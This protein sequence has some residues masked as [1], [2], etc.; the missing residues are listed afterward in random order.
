MKFDTMEEFSNSIKQCIADDEDGEY[1]AY[2]DILDNLDLLFANFDRLNEYLTPSDLKIFLNAV[3][4][5]GMVY[6]SEVKKFITK[7]KEEIKAELQK[8][9]LSHYS[10]FDPIVRNQK[11]QLPSFPVDML[12]VIIKTYIKEVSESI[13]VPDDMVASMVLIVMS[14]CMQG[15]FYIN[16]K[17]DW[18]ESL[19]LYVVVVGRPS[20]RKS[21]T[22]KEVTR[23]IF[24]YV[25]EENKRRKPLIAE[26]ELKKKILS[27]KL[28]T[29]QE[30]LSRKG[31]KPKYTLEDA[32]DCQK[33]LEDLEEV[34]ALRLIVD[35]VTSEAL[36][37]AMKDNGERMGIISAEGGIFGM[38]AGRYNTNT[39]IDIFLKGYSGEYYSSIRVGRAETDLTH[40]YLTIGLMVQP[41]VIEDIMD[42]K[43]FRGKG[44]LAR[45]LYTVPNTKVGERVYRTKEVSA[46]ARKK[47]ED[48]C[49]E[50]LDIPDLTGFT[51][52]V[53]RLSPEADKL[54]EEFYMW[55]EHQLTNEL[56]EIEDW[57][58]K[59]H[60][61][62]M[63][64]AGVLHVIKHKLNSVNVPVE[65][66]TMR[67][68]IEIGK[69]YL[70]HSKV[71]F[72]IMGLS[73]P[74]EIQDAKYIISRLGQND[75]NDKNDFIPKR[76]AIRL[77]Q[78]FK[79]VEEMEPGLRCLEEHG[80]IAIIKESQGR[81]R[82]SEKICINPEYYK[83][84]ESN[85]IKA[86]IRN[87]L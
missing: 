72:D 41:Q 59:L 46:L 24:Q 62:T 42:N 85:G 63:R 18:T 68:A 13:Q 75:L 14:L 3:Q 40:P 15:K 58:G 21:P 2:S 20:E 82:P 29:I 47:Y 30:A 36:V 44:L 52:R 70:E 56:E 26:Y 1:F 25:S 69:Y 79:T 33:Q 22:L 74:P 65:E 80:Y 66:D 51:E 54:A 67:S 76:E 28:R 60:G 39:N 35:D 19:N 4:K 23:P 16:I 11:K 5:P 45:F 87:V 71:A 81:G 31:S 9:H 83:W 53:I 38:M 48:L 12:P 50:L 8:S 27:G 32:I 64:I 57:A 37:K 6:S 7:K 34:K 77:C 61:N 73:D 17:P 86:S 43:D 49:K 10:H 78:K 55:I 84:K